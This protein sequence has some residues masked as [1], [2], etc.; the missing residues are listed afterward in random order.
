MTMNDE[1]SK[2]STFGLVVKP[3][4]GRI[5]L[6]LFSERFQDKKGHIVDSGHNAIRDNKFTTN[7]S[8]GHFSIY[9]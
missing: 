2:T 7:L 1:N 3:A 6:S 4:D 9:F 5:R 8:E